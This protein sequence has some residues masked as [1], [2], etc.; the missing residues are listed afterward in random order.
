MTNILEN[1]YY[2]DPYTDRVRWEQLQICFYF[3]Y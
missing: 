1:N 2:T 3:K